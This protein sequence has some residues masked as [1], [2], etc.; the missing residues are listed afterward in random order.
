MRKIIIL[1]L[2]LLFFLSDLGISVS[3]AQEEDF[4]NEWIV[5]SYRAIAEI[6]ADG[7]LAVEEY[8]TYRFTK[9][10]S[11]HLK[12]EIDTFTASSMDNIGIFSILEIN[13]EDITKS[14]LEEIEADS[15]R[16]I[17]DQE[18]GMVKGLELSLDA[19]NRQKTVVFKYTLYDL[20]AVY[21]DMALLD[22]SFL[23]KLDNLY[24]G[25]ISISVKMPKGTRMDSIQSLLMGP[26]YAQ[27]VIGEDTVEFDASHFG[28][29][30]DLRLI[31]LL[32]TSV[33]PQG[34][35]K[36][37]NDITDEIMAEMSQ[38]EKEIEE[39]RRNYEVRHL[40]FRLLTYV[41]IGL[42][43]LAFIYL[44]IRY[45]KDPKT[46]IK[47]KYT[48]KLP[49]DYY[50][51]AELGVLMNKGKV[52]ANYIIATLIDL[53]NRGYLDIEL[54]D[55]DH[56]FYL[57]KSPDASTEQLKSHE[58]YLLVWLFDDFGQDSQRVSTVKFE[59]WIRDKKNRSRYKH[60]Y[61]TWEKLV[62]FNASKWKFFENIK[63]AKL[64]G[65]IFGILTF[66]S[67]IILYLL[68][69][70]IKGST[71]VG[72]SLL[73]IIYSQFIFKRTEFGALNNAQWLSFIRYIKE[74][75]K[76]KL[77]NPEPGDWERFLGYA[78]P[79]GR[80]G[81]IIEQF[82]KIYSSTG[83]NHKSLFLLRKEN[84]DKTDH[85][86]NSIGRKHFVFGKAN[87]F[88]SLFGSRNITIDR[89]G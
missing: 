85:W 71:V 11:G 32:P 30:G 64:T 27:Q 39:V 77:P 47:Q 33:I 7:S 84:L 2:I 29:D 23:N 40:T 83:L 6:N 60:K 55:S 9:G 8:I 59:E 63:K 37:E 79:I 25:N 88:S 65:L 34:R 28:Y 4:S 76:S 87:K 31:M 56:G 78:I 35:K 58:E 41:S 69:D 19:E 61:K 21:K 48:N 67:G 42:I 50:T 72:L 54:S 22:W 86:I 49:V 38:Y 16:I 17:Y 36:I 3:L 5:D 14:K 24:T 51:P 80:A 18:Y 66:I 75:T 57:S 12:R 1:V 20:L 89:K 44:Y 62:T 68:G 70:I 73:L 15:Y 43:A 52:K 45:D 53:I 13:Q 74:P 82:P 26:L 10:F 46:G 81:H